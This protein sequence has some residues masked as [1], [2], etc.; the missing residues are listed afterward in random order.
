MRWTEKE[1]E[2][3]KR[4]YPN[5]GLAIPKLKRG[6]SA[7]IHKAYCLKIKS[8]KP[9]VGLNFGQPW[10]HNEDQIIR[11][12]YLKEGPNLIIPNRTKSAILHRASR[13]KIHYCTPWTQ[14][15]ID[16]V[17]NRF[18]EDWTF[19]PLL[20]RS[21]NAIQKKAEQ[22]GIRT[23]N[24]LW[25]Q[26][27][28]I[29][30]REDYNHKGSK[31]VPSRACASVGVMARRFGLHVFRDTPNPIFF[32]ELNPESAYVIGFIWADGNLWE[33]TLRIFQSESTILKKIL[34][35][36]DSKQ[37]IKSYNR[38][39]RKNSKTEFSISFKCAALNEDLLNIG[40]H[41]NKSKSIRF[42]KHLPSELY[43]HFVR[44]FFDGDGSI[45]CRKR[46]KSFECS[47]TLASKYLAE[48]LYKIL[49]E[50]TPSLTKNKKYWF[51]RFNSQTLVPFGNWMY[52]D[53]SIHLD[54]KYQK[55][56][57]AGCDI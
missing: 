51:L 41:A 29:D 19:I 24:R 57:L 30:L 31:A 53:S 14:T 12:R 50:F 27:E 6:K 1:I 40:L 34:K 11:K 13:L 54:R 25:T 7:I 33:N 2:I 39:K 56:K 35:V 36:M 49:N 15:E 55:F 17:K 48:G 5:K 47:I 21:R 8:L 43:S 9:R 3:L 18:P 46:N 4:E 52:K 37:T 42:P 32:K 20:K 28:K 45:W 22:L 38:K 26:K 44:G 23:K 10:S 16:I